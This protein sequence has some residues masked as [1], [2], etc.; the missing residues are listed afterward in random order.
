MRWY[1][2]TIETWGKSTW[3]QDPLYDQDGNQVPLFVE[4]SA[5][6]YLLVRDSKPLGDLVRIIGSKLIISEKA[7]DVL[8]RYR[9]DDAVMQRVVHVKRMGRLIDGLVYYWLDSRIDRDVLDQSR[10]GFTKSPVTRNPLVIT[11]W[12]LARDRIPDCDL[13]SGNIGIWFCSE[14]LRGA[15]LDNNLTNFGFEEVEVSSH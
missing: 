10:A 3:V 14:Q 12:V 6:V 8:S 2:L 13:F 7:Q 1:E 9:L 15:I 5:P 4:S 11:K